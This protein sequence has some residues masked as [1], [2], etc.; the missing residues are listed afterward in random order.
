MLEEVGGLHKFMGWNRSLL[1][2]RVHVQIPESS[3][4]ELQDSGGY[5]MVSLLKLAT[6]TEVN[7]PVGQLC[8][9]YMAMCDRMEFNFSHLMIIQKLVS[10]DKGLTLWSS[11]ELSNRS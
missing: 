7:T 2:V 4:D 1:T 9:H 3:I 5:Q 10:C 8:Y 6:I 11:Y